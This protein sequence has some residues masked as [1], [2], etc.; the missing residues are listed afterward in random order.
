MEDFKRWQ[1]HLEF[2]STPTHCTHLKEI[3]SQSVVL[4]RSSVLRAAYFW[5]FPHFPEKLWSEALK[6]AV[7]I[8][9]RTPTDGL[10]AKAPLD[11]WERKPLVS[12][13]HMH[14]WGALAFK[15]IEVR[16]RNGKLTSRAKKM[17]LVG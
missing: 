17:H 10:G 6:A 2:R 11:V 5:E 12:I 8:R 3:L 14:E 15:H 9:N 16:Q 7:Y 4:E 1:S 13:K